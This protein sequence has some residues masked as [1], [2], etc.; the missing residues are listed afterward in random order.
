MAAHRLFIVD[1]F[2]EEKY[3]G[4]QLA[5]ITDAARLS[6]AEMQKIARETNFSETTFIL[7]ATQRGGC[8][9]VRIFT[10][11]A[12]IPFAGHPTLGTA[13][14]LRHFIA[15]ERP[16]RIVVNLQ[17]A[18][19]PV[20]FRA[21]A[22]GAELAWM[23]PTYPTFGRRLDPA[24]FAELLDLRRED[25]DTAFPVEE[26]S[27][28]VPFTFVPVKTLAAIK[29]A[30]F[31]QDRYEH[32]SHMGFNPCLF[33]ISRETYSPA[34]QLNV[35][36]FAGAFGVAEDP[37][38]G[39]ANACLAAYVLRHSYLPGDTVD[40]RV[41]QGHEIGRPSLLQVRAQRRGEQA[42]IEVGGRVIL[43]ARGEL[44]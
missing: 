24:P 14:V 35:R 23:Q 30:R 12:E 3:A 7:S 33:L 28:G 36:M 34:N 43:S 26:V 17:L 40:V 9:D 6:A 5:V 20:T 10:P 41:E 22:D 11:V 21:R 18:P 29:R 38:T 2:A 25:L 15:P 42:D 8:Y 37:A 13:W 44:V 16:Q 32:V 31:R 19:I 1:V 27:L 39:S 4:N